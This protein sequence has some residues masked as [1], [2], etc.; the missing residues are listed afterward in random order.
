MSKQR[1]Y[2]API[3]GKPGFTAWLEVLDHV[4]RVCLGI[5]L[6]WLCWSFAAPGIELY[7]LFAILCAIGTA[8]RGWQCL[9]SLGKL[10]IQRRKWARFEA[11][12]VAPKADPM[13]G[14]QQLR[15]RGL[16]K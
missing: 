9:W 16:L 7:G 3:S 2:D 13:A 12:G 10:L 14:T 5:A 8:I 6:T 4:W 15:D 11:Q 1:S